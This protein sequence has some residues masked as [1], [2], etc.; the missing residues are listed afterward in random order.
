FCC[1]FWFWFF[2]TTQ[3]IFV[4]SLGG[5]FSVNLG[6]LD[7]FTVFGCHFVG[8][9][10]G[11]VFTFSV[12]LGFAFFQRVV[13]FVCRFVFDCFFFGHFALVDHGDSNGSVVIDGLIRLWRNLIVLPYRYTGIIQNF[14]NGGGGSEN[15]F[16]VICHRD[17]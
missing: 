11:T 4:S 2:G 12:G 15:F 6:L 5:H 16:A 7:F 13:V 17:I 1:W 3:N 10:I 8:D 14:L 9:C